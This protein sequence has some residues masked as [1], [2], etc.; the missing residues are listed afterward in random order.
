MKLNNDCIRDLLI[1]LENT[2]GYHE[3]LYVHDIKLKDYSSD[4]LSYTVEKLMEAN[5]LNCFG[6]IYSTH[7]IPLTI[8]SIT[9]QGHQFLDSIRNEDVWSNAKN[10]V[11]T[12]GSITLPIL[13]DLCV[14]YLRQKFGLP[15]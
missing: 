3:R 7:S 10:K 6:G 14:S 5:F 15:N 9:Y 8:D 1:Y 2:L 4:E 12:V 13:Q 11:K